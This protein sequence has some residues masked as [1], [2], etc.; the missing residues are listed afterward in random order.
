MSYILNINKSLK[1]IFSHM[2]SIDNWIR[3]PSTHPYFNGKSALDIMLHG[4]VTDLHNVTELTK[5]F[6]LA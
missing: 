6:L 4:N 1:I 5:T 2:D 3:K